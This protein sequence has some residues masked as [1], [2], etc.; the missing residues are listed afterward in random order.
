MDFL[1][2]GEETERLRFRKLVPA[3]FELWLPFHK[4]KRTSEFWNGLPQ[5][6]ET[7]CEQDFERTFYRYSNHLGGKQALILK[8]TGELIGLCGLLVQEVDG[9]KELEIAYSLLPP[10]WK[11]GFATEAAVKC[12]EFAFHNQLAESL[13]SIIHIGNV[14]SQKVALNNG[15]QLDRTT[16][17]NNNPVHIFRIRS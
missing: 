11:R 9:Q 1:L 16:T 8:G 5:D 13:V 4:D 12:R 14:P 6:P 2:H 10:F 15:M 7:A 17:Y 3:D